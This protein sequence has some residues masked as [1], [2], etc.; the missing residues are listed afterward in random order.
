MKTTLPPVAQAT[1]SR[2]SK[3]TS[4]CPTL[5]RPCQPALVSGLGSHRQWQQPRRPQ[6]KTRRLM[7]CG[8]ECVWIER[9]LRPQPI[10][11][12]LCVHRAPF[13]IRMPCAVRAGSGSSRCC[14]STP[15]ALTLPLP[16]PP[17]GPADCGAARA[18][19]AY[20]HDGD[21][22]PEPTQIRSVRHRADAHNA[23]PSSTHA[24]SHINVLQACQTEHTTKRIVG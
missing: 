11:I 10:S 9:R 3:P 22:L 2:R 21:P 17:P 1:P 4:G 8:F 12:V 15:S 19:K 23:A 13:R 20:Q 14:T 5:S 16:P 24:V 6:C 7:S 18:G